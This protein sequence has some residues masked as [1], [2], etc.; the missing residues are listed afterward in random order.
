MIGFG[1]NELATFLAVLARAAAWAFT[2]PIIGERAVPARIRMMAA[3][4]FSLAVLPS[5]EPLP[6]DA[7]YSALPV[8]LCFGLMLGA[9]S[10]LV[11]AGAEAGGQLIGIQLG[12]GFAGTFDPEAQ[13]ES[14]ATRKIAFYLAGL[15][16]LQAGG[17]ETAIRAL[18]APAI[19]PSALTEILSVLIRET[20]KVLVHAVRIAAPLL[21]ASF[22]ANVAVALASRA[23]PGLN[24]FSVMLGL[25]LALGG[26]VLLGTSPD[27]A[28][29]M[30]TA[31][32][33]ARDAIQRTVTR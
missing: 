7:L 14:I 22:V 18:A 21:L 17:L 11:L 6:M 32:S 28:R 10:R 5:R 33:L 31:G 23:S 24:V 15:A 27:F 29:E 19:P 4:L 12:L 30:A 8:E 9:A 16:F 20:P 25:F 2:S 3:V 13:D 1:E 26:L